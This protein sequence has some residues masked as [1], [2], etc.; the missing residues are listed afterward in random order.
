MSQIIKRQEGGN[1]PKLF[2]YSQG[3]IETD[4]LV[5][6]ISQN[7]DSYLESKNWTRKQKDKFTNSV[8]NFIEGIENSYITSM[9]PTGQFED[10]RGKDRGVSNDN[11]NL[12]FKQDREAASFI[13]K[14]LLAQTPYKQEEE[15]EQ[16]KSPFNLNT[17]FTKSFNKDILNR[18]SD[19]LDAKV[20]E[21]VSPLYKGKEYDTIIN[22]LYKLETDDWGIFGNKE[23]FHNKLNQEKEALKDNTSYKNSLASLTRLGLDADII[24]PFFKDSIPVQTTTESTDTEST[25]QQGNT[26]QQQTPINNVQK[27]EAM[28]RNQESLDYFN[29]QIN[30]HPVSRIYIQLGNPDISN[31]AMAQIL[32]QNGDKYFDLLVNTIGFDAGRM[33]KTL[34]ALTKEL[35]K[36]I[37]SKVYLKGK[38]I[39]DTQRTAY[40]MLSNILP[41][42]LQDRNKMLPLQDGSTKYLVIPSITTENVQGA[43]VYDA[44]SKR[45]YYKPLY[46]LIKSPNVI[47]LFQ[48]ATKNQQ[49]GVLKFKLEN[50]SKIKSE[51][52]PKFNFNTD[53]NSNI[54]WDF[55]NRYK[56]SINDNKI[57]YSIR[58]NN[59]QDSISPKNG[60]YDPEEGGDLIENQQWW[61]NWSNQL[62]SNE[63]LAKQWAED[64]IKKNPSYGEKYKD[65]W[66]DNNSFNFKKFQDSKSLWSDKMNGIG[67]DFYKGKVYKIKDTDTY[68][69]LEEFQK[70][71]YQVLGENKES[72]PYLTVYDVVDKKEKT[73]VNPS[74]KGLKLNF[75]IQDFIKNDFGTLGALVRYRNNSKGN[76]AILEEALNGYKPFYKD[77]PRFERYQYGDY[78]TINQAQENSEGMQEIA[79]QNLTSN[80][81]IEAMKQLEAAGKIAELKQ[82]ANTINSNRIKET[83]EQSL[84]QAKENAL[85]RTNTA[86]ENAYNAWNNDLLESQVKQGYLARKTQ[87]K[88]LLLQELQK[89]YQDRIN[90]QLAVD[91]QEL[92]MNLSNKYL[93]DPELK[94]MQEELE[95]WVSEGKP[96]NSYPRLKEFKKLKTKLE[97]QYTNELIR[98]KNKIYGLSMNTNKGF[99]PIKVNKK[100]GSITSTSYKRI[101]KMKQI[102]KADK[103]YQKNIQDSI[104]NTNKMLDLLS[105]NMSKLISS[106][107]K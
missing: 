13:K 7:L 30:G 49:G 100:G 53:L 101:E 68:G 55:N 65:L 38:W 64:Y 107:I 42:Y 20:L 78:S 8:N 94:L 98:G 59:A 15:K 52:T 81:E 77:A 28:F 54:V 74:N 19:S 40:S 85:Q 75:N 104:K 97:E 95:Q 102:L 57:N 35:G 93:N 23:N 17:L 86:N 82:Q 29:K 12:F 87:N 32:E 45:L 37:N 36:N 50:T 14:V 96:V 106:V 83:S 70:L 31:S 27:L 76:K 26:T 91:V 47:K 21:I 34:P 103:I 43:L 72:T 61:N 10:Y 46:E 33:K 4:R 3:S 90:K 44:K 69:P 16:K 41:Y 73:V 92:T 58:D 51:N 6:A 80:P 56:H 99:T 39:D 2:K 1:V 66:F 63:S 89:L 67:H 11:G 71:G 9:S 84:A 60:Y 24:A 62:L 79:S 88:D 22:Q 25:V 48:Q 105:K 5:N 18:D